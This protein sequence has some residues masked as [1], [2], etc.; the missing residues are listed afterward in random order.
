M[1][2]PSDSEKERLMRLYKKYW[3]KLE[4]LANQNN[5]LQKLLDEINDQAESGLPLYA[6]AV[7]DKIKDNRGIGAQ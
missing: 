5:F 2:N 6:Q 1:S 4:F 3:A 7:I